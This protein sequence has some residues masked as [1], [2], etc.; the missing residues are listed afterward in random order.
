[1]PE[2]ISY[3]DNN[4][5][6]RVAPEVAEAMRPY[7]EDAY[8]NPSSLYRM[9][10]GAKA[11]IEQAREEVAALVGAEPDEIV[12]TSCGTESDNTAVLSALSRARVGAPLVTTRVEHAAVGNLAARLRG[13][14]RPVTEL[15][16]DSLGRIDLD[17]I[18]RALAA[19]AGALSVMWA[20]NE[21]GVLFPVPE[22]AEAAR[23]HGVPFHTDAVQAV[24]KIPIDLRKVPVDYLALSGHKLHAP[25]GI[26]ALF[27]RRGASF[28]TLLVGGHQEHG[29]RGGTE[30]VASIAGLG[31]AARLARE[32]MDEENARIGALRDRL[33]EGLL[34]SCPGARLNGDPVNRLPNTSNVSFEYIEGESILL[35]LD[36]AGI[37]ASSGSACTTGSLEPSPV[38]RAMGVPYTAAHGSVRFSLSRYSTDADVDKALEVLP[39]II[40]KLRA[41]S[42]FGREGAKT[43]RGS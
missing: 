32:Q 30:N 21:T 18:R 35:L 2:A 16:V 38:Q 10:G 28:R 34:K 41:L 27:V 17:E 13:E 29:R 6:T 3:L 15:G 23:S 1:M 31:V 24:A 25:K 37:A 43:A 12:F 36:R 26:G 40:A 33:E 4:A 14:G 5:T 9:A 11:A 8:G 19:G 22:I 7:L 20:N 42:P 39:G